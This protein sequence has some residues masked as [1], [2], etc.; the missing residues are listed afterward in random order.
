VL[1]DARLG[2]NIDEFRSK[3]GRPAHEEILTRTATLR[4]R[5]KVSHDESF[6]PG[7]FAV[8]VAFLD[9]TACEIVLRSYEKKNSAA[10]ARLVQPVLPRFRVEDF[11]TPKSD[12]NGIQIYQL[13]DGTS[14]SVKEHRGHTIVVV[15]GECFMR[16]EDVFDR[17]AAK[18]RPPTSNH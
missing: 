8:E 2:A 1:A 6:V 12:V 11:A 17:E 16:N 7:A 14:V 18:V 9:K 3:W 4:W 5:R 15:K 10:I 13:A